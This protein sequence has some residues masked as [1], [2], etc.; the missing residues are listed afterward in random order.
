MDAILIYNKE[1]YIFSFYHCDSHF[2]PYKAPS[3]PFNLHKILQVSS[4][5]YI[6]KDGLSLDGSE[7]YQNGK[8]CLATRHLHMARLGA[9]G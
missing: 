7:I 2:I 9:E 3:E 8:L 5:R 1:M 4:S 6:E